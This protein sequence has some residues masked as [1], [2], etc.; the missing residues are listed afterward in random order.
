MRVEELEEYTGYSLL[1]RGSYIHIS[2]Y[3][4]RYFGSCHSVRF[5][6]CQ[7]RQSN[8]RHDNLL[9]TCR[10][11]G[12]QRVV[13]R[14]YIGP[15]STPTL[16]PTR[17]CWQDA[18]LSVTGESPAKDIKSISDIV[19]EP[20]ARGC[21]ENVYSE[22]G[23]ETCKTQVSQ[24]SAGNISN[25]KE[26]MLSNEGYIICTPVH[27]CENGYIRSQHVEIQKRRPLRELRRFA[28]DLWKGGSEGGIWG[29]E[30]VENSG[31]E[32]LLTW[33]LNGWGQAAKKSKSFR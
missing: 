14:A 13:A 2:R 31:K 4:Y 15:H 32:D 11:S 19:I 10:G 22:V 20:K 23:T 21:L 25:N 16:T 9:A 28:K 29:A 7:S 26:N 30:G 18:T 1:S 24:I 12:T 33:T 6:F 3:A 17:P 5:F 8:H 27:P